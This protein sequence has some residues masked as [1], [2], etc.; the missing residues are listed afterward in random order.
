M[1][2]K[3]DW[4]EF[5]DA[6]Q[7]RPPRQARRHPPADQ[8]QVIQGENRKSQR[9]V[10]AEPGPVKVGP[11]PRFRTPHAGDMADVFIPTNRGAWLRRDLASRNAGIGRVGRHEKYAA[12]AVDAFAFLRGTNHL[13]WQDL[14]TSPGLGEFGGGADTRIWLQGDMHANNLGSFAD[15]HGAVVYDANDFDEASL[16]DYQLD[17]WRLA[18]SIVLIAGGHQTLTEEDA[19]DCVAACADGYL[20]TIHRWLDAGGDAVEVFTAAN[21]YGQLDDFLERI[22]AE[23]S[24]GAMLARYTSVDRQGRRILDPALCPDLGRAPATMVAALVEDLPAY[25]R[26]LGGGLAYDQDHFAVL[27]IA[28]RLHAGIGSLGVPRYYVLIAGGGDGP[29]ILDVKAQPPPSAFLHG[30]PIARA[31]TLAGCAGH[32][33]RRVTLGAR[34][35][36]HAADDYQGWLTCAGRQWSVR[37]RS[38]W[39]ATLPVSLLTSRRRLEKMAAQWGMVLATCHCRA[40][41]WLERSG[42]G[43]A[44]GVAAQTKGRRRAFRDQVVRVATAYAAQVALDF[45]AFRP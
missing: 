6:T 28:K 32:H 33:G 23:Q 19:R 34:A 16:G 40:D 5:V 37:R 43:F 29:V 30:D 20:D 26:T 27:S 18:V 36:G 13:F 7:E 22:A 42:S 38:P 12:M 25:G 45:A 2:L 17:L 44:V 35:L 24:P 3:G 31:A 41:R 9:L 11:W 21:T 8:D 39:K 1:C 14:G 15:A 4:Y 10:P